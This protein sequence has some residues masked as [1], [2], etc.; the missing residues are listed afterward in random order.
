[1][2]V[3]VCVFFSLLPPARLCQPSTPRDEGVR[4][5]PRS[6]RTLRAR[7]R[8]LTIGKGSGHRAHGVCVCVC[9]GTPVPERESQDSF[10]RHNATQRNAQDGIARTSA[11]CPRAIVTKLF[12][13][14]DCV[15]VLRVCSVCC[16]L[17]CPRPRERKV[18]IFATRELLANTGRGS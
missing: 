9:G 14:L 13:L 3:C 8:T 12:F 6:A 1:M 18:D 17:V 11:S 7:A 2:Y 15:C 10:I 4:T 16:H 5:P